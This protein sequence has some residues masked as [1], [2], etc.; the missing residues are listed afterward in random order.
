MITN[1]TDLD[2][3]LIKDFSVFARELGWRMV[4]Y[5]GY[6]LDFAVGKITRDH[7][8]IDLVFYGQNDRYIAEQKITSYLT[9]KLESPT[10]KIE[11]NDFQLV[12]D[13]HANKYVLNLYYVQTQLSPYVDLH[14]VI[15][16][17]G[18]IVVNDPVMFPPPQKGSLAGINV[19][20]QDQLAHKK[21]ILS[22]GDTLSEKRKK[23][24]DL[25]NTLSSSA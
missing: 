7:G 24:I 8:D 15:K 13:V 18:E 9:Q 17:Y 6:G 22:K 23:D 11:E 1:K 12:I 10:F 3:K 5:G 4:V 2:L 25:I 21:D 16:K 20:V 14:H 19:E